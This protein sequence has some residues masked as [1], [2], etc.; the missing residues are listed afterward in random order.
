MGRMKEGVLVEEGENVG[1]E[2]VGSGFRR[3][4]SRRSEAV[5]DFGL[6]AKTGFGID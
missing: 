5:V 4:V 2:G 6:V 3:E 1:G